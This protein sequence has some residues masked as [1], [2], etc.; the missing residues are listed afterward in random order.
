MSDT[1][2]DL[3]SMRRPWM[4]VKSKASSW[5]ENEAERGQ[6]KMFKHRGDAEENTWSREAS[7][8]P[9]L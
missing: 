4:N 8:G 7:R 1:Q 6:D 5:A 9:K 3:H 2:A